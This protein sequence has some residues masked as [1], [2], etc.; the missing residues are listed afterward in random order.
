MSAIEKTLKIHPGE[1][2]SDGL[3]TFSEIEGLGACVNAPMVQI[4]DD[5]YEDLTPETMTSLLQALQAAAETTGASGQAPGLAGPGGKLTGETENRGQHV[6]E[7]VARAKD[8]G[9]GYSAGGATL[10]SPG[11]LSGRKTC[12]PRTGLTALVGEPLTGEQMMRK[13][14]VLD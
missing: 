1:T 6:G 3:F 13:D 10:P 12:E 4:N 7:G 8:Q 9:R 2:T 5:Y 11:P 14:G